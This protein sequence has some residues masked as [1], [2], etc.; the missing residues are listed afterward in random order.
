MFRITVDRYTLSM[1][2]SLPATYDEYRKRVKLVEIFDSGGQGEGYF[3]LSVAQGNDWPFLIV[4][5]RYAPGPE[6]GFHPG[7]LLVPETQLLFIGAGERLL[8][9]R[10]GPPE[11][12]W[13]QEVMIGFWGWQ[14]YQQF[15]I[16][17]AELELAVWNIHGEK[18]WSTFVEPPWSYTIERDTIHLDVMGKQSSFSLPFGPTFPSHS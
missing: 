10:L 1:S 18:L 3:Y 11:K 8:A 5:Q 13:E 4:A 9:Y 15:V 2:S 6:S 14:R 17:S 7:V 16:M 12:L